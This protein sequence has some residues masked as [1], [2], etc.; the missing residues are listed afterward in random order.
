[1]ACVAVVHGGSLCDVTSVAAFQDQTQLTLSQ[2]VSARH[3]TQ[4]YRFGKL[5]LLLPALKAVSAQTIEELFFRRTIG[6]IPIVRLLSDMYR[7]TFER[8]HPL[9]LLHQSPSSTV[10]T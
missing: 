7:A 10:A 8:A 3:P 9:A 2:Y 1:M 5:L 6:D 4:P